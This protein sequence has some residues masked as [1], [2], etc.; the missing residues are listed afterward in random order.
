MVMGLINRIR[1]TYSV[2]KAMG[3]IAANPVARHHIMQTRGLL[4]GLEDLYFVESCRG[5]PNALIDTRATAKAVEVAL[6]RASLPDLLQ[7]RVNG[8]PKVHDM[9]RVSISGCPNGCSRPQ[10]RDFGVSGRLYPEFTPEL[11]TGCGA[12]QRACREGAI[13]MVPSKDADMAHPNI[14]LGECIGCGACVRVC[15]ARAL[16]GPAVYSISVGGKL[17]RH[18][19]LAKHLI[20]AT[21]IEETTAVIVAATRW[22][23]SNAR[24][25]QRFG[26]V[27]EE[28]GMDALKEAAVLGG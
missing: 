15:P 21:S 7:E 10:I 6:I 4:K 8:E 5:C 9:L 12:C 2:M 28:V 13:A 24:P 16:A 18:P 1:Q 3:A 20:D 26:A 19:R 25:H 17:G 23:V 14:D 27:I 11:C 22:F